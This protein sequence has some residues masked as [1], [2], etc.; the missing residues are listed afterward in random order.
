MGDALRPRKID[1]DHLR[2]SPGFLGDS[3]KVS[4][5]E[6]SQKQR[7]FG[8]RLEGDLVN[9]G[10]GFSESPPTHGF[11]HDAESSTSRRQRVSCLSHKGFRQSARGP[12][13][14]RFERCEPGPEGNRGGCFRSLEILAETLGLS[15]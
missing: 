14:L 5:R 8:D 1:K 9:G 13:S 11:T 10:F 6:R 4:A 15:I 3:T 12:K 7:Q 2:L